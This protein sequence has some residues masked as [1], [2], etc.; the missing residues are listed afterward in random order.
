MAKA[1]AGWPRRRSAGWDWSVERATVPANSAAANN[2]AWP[3]PG[4]WFT[5]HRFYLAD[6]PTGD[7]DR[8]TATEVMS[9]V[10]GIHRELGTTVVMV[11]HDEETA[12]KIAD[13]VVRLRD[14]R[15]VDG[16][17]GSR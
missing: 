12:L 1:V 16:R 2:S 3:W 17:E 7:L 8:T 10:Q 9:L 15:I 6:E 14:G 4:R 11:T 5:I 13:R